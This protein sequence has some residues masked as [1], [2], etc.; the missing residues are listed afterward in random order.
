M[1][2]AY[3][4]IKKYLEIV[5]PFENIINNARKINND[6]AGKIAFL[7]I[8]PNNNNNTVTITNCAIIIGDVMSI[9]NIYPSL[10]L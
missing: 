8:L 4:N 7:F 1:E 6:I 2:T 5:M 9:K 3:N 10:L